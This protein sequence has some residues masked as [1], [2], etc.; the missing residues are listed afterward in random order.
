MESTRHM[1][2]DA[3]ATGPFVRLGHGTDRPERAMK[4]FSPLHA[5]SLKHF[6]FSLLPKTRGPAMIDYLLNFFYE[7]ALSSYL[8]AMPSRIRLAEPGYTSVL[9]HN[10]LNRLTL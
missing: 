5:V 2:P 1:E 3:R 9:T 7:Q 6:R 8:S 10:S 4:P